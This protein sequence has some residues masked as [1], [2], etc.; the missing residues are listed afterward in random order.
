MRAWFIVAAAV[1]VLAQIA[2]ARADAPLRPQACQEAGAALDA[3][4]QKIDYNPQT[5]EQQ[6]EFDRLRDLMFGA[7]ATANDCSIQQDKFTSA[8]KYLA[9]VQHADAKTRAQAASNLSDAQ[10][11]RDFY[12]DGKAPAAPAAK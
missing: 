12:C 11:D 6:R 1:F 10:Q 5:P 4:K 3:Y 8:Q 7:C 9:S 2:E